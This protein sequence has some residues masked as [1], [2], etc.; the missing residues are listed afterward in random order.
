MQ[1]IMVLEGGAVDVLIREALAAKRAGK[2]LRVHVRTG[3]YP[4]VMVEGA[5]VWTPTLGRRA[6]S[7]G[8]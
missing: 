6:D 8:H 1:D 5:G 3:D 7:T 2:G 4:G